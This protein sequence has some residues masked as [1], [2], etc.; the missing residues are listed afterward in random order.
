MYEGALYLFILFIK[1]F[2]Q[3]LDLI[4]LIHQA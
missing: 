1:Y 4:L 3:L 2:N